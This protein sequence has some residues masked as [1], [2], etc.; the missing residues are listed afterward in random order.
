MKFQNRGTIF[1][2]IVTI[3]SQ[4]F[5]CLILRTSVVKFEVIKFSSFVLHLTIYY[6]ICHETLDNLRPVGA[7]NPS[8]SCSPYFI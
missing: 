3:M 5:L 8:F 4:L 7:K 1:I 2:D 6:S